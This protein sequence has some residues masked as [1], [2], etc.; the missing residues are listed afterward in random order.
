MPRPGL[1]AV[2]GGSLGSWA[3]TGDLPPPPGG[4]H[5][6]FKGEQGWVNGTPR[7]AVILD[8]PEGRLDRT[9]CWFVCPKCMVAWTASGRG[10]GHRVSRG[11]MRGA[12]HYLSKLG[13]ER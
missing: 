1:P 10:H 9:Q 5:V 3:H 8:A 2:A 13:C 12:P 4:N 7:V 11:S 6:R